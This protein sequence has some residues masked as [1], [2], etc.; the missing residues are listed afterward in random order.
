MVE[1]GTDK[2]WVALRYLGKGLIK[3]VE[4]SDVHAYA[5]KTKLVWVRTITGQHTHTRNS[6]VHHEYATNQ[7]SILVDGVINTM[8]IVLEVQQDGI[9]AVVVAIQGKLYITKAYFDR[10]GAKPN[11]SLTI[12]PEEELIIWEKIIW[13]QQL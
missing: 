9:K 2:S 3:Y 10:N 5:I 4:S 8:F 13:C 6:I 12:T 11:T 1:A 7:V